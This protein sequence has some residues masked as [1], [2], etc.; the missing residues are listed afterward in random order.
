MEVKIIKGNKSVLGA[1][2]KKL[3]N[4]ELQHIV[5]SAQMMK[6]RL[7]VIIL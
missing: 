3:R 4:L 2:H 6:I 5:E 1:F 7:K